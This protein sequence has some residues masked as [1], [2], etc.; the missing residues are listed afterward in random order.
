MSDRYYRHV[1]IQ[2][3][4]EKRDCKKLQEESKTN[5]QLLVYKSKPKKYTPCECV[6]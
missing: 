2:I 4:H 1:N 6:K 5:T 3:Y